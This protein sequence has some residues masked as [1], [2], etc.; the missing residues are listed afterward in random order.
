[1]NKTFIYIFL[2]TIGQTAFAHPTSYKG[3]VG[4]M[5]YNTPQM[6][7]ILLTY[8]LS[9]NFAVAT[10]YLRDSKSEFYIPRLN[11][12]VKRWNNE[13][14]QGNI[15]LSGGAGYEK[16]DSKNYGVRLAELV[17]DWE[18]RKYYVYFDHLY[19]NRDNESN[20]A[21]VEKEYNHS[22]FRVGTAPF[23]ADYADLNVWLILQAE[24]HLNQDQIEM[25]QFLRFY[26]K[27]TLWEVGAGFNG[28]WAFNYMVHF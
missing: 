12:L 9:H 28:N 7:E 8:S 4:L 16:F 13:D 21:L 23:L 27:N 2:I 5:S 19:L 25:T 20:P 11:F 3:A 6:N 26:I 18:S 1:M 17:M 22:K 15:Y 10:T 24:K 14:S